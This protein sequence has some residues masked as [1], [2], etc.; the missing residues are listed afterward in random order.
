MSC[1]SLTIA[2]NLNN[3]APSQYFDMPFDSVVEFNGQTVFF[4]D[5]G[6]YEEG[7]NDDDGT[8]IDA[9][10]DTPN[11][12]FGREEQKSIAAFSMRYEV[13]SGGEMNVTLYGDEDETY[14]RTFLIPPAKSG[15]VQQTMR[16]TLRTY[17]YGKAG[18]WKVRIANVNGEDF[19]I[20]TFR[21]APVILKRHAY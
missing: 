4:G 8:D 18:D 14:A 11:H 19:S 20:D 6:I 1:D 12:N 13:E 21:L 5:D 7:G 3:M 16:K 15:Q 9:W 17:K 2:M 10:I